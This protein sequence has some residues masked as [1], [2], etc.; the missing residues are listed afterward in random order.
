[1][2]RQPSVGGWSFSFSAYP[3]IDVP[4][5]QRDA[6]MLSTAHAIYRIRVCDFLFSFFF[7]FSVSHLIEFLEQLN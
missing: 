6:P 3:Q 7:F 4:Q 2:S 1:M 5:Y